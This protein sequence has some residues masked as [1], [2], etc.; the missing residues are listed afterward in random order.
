[1]V[2]DMPR[3]SEERRLA[4]RRR[5]LDAMLRL[6]QRTGLGA[7]TMADVI[8]ESGLSAGAIYGYFASKEEILV[9]VARE[10]VGGRAVAIADMAEATPVPH[11]AELV[12]TLI[13]SI[14]SGALDGGAIVQVWGLAAS[15]P[16]LRETATEVL[17]E[18]QDVVERHLV[19][20][21]TQEGR[22]EPAEDARRAAPAL[23]GLVQGYIVRTALLGPLD[24]E[25]HLRGIDVLLARPEG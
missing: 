20:W 14:P 5:I 8:A 9:A 19:R 11:P 3:I 13:A 21:F 17:M 12:R 25:D 2:A 6:I 7:V 23:I 24:T 15:Q 4:Q 10:I 16:G 22:A 18:L 1:M